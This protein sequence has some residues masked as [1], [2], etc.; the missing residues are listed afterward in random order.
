MIFPLRS[1]FEGS[2]YH[3]SY[4]LPCFTASLLVSF[5]YST[6]KK[7]KKTNSFVSV[8]EIK[9]K[10]QTDL[11]KTPLVVFWGHAPCLE[12]SE[13]DGSCFPSWGGDKGDAVLSIAR[14]NRNTTNGMPL[15]RESIFAAVLQPTGHNGKDG[16]EHRSLWKI[17]ITIWI[18]QAGDC[19]SPSSLLDPSTAPREQLHRCLPRQI[20]ATMFP[21]WTDL[22]HF[23]GSLGVPLPLGPYQEIELQWLCR[24][25]SWFPPTI[26]DPCRQAAFPLGRHLVILSS[27]LCPLQR[28]HPQEGS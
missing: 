28:L 13:T 17:R 20:R 16:G 5:W 18:T 24:R 4:A 22:W 14:R 6:K 9:W 21:L 10:E 7:K 1:G 15:R 11:N 25:G 3:Q 27:F 23:A 26:Q 19:W 12:Q 2:F 8:V